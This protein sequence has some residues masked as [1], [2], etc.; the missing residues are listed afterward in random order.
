MKVQRLNN[1]AEF[2][3]AATF[4]RATMGIVII[5]MIEIPLITFH[6]SQQSV[7]LMVKGKNKHNKTIVG[8]REDSV[9]K[10]GGYILS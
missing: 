4:Q 1:F 10:R 7:R 9:L 8:M 3:N 2:L 6:T 5:R